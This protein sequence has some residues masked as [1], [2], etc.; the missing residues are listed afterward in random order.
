MT[1]LDRE[2]LNRIIELLENT[3]SKED[4]Y[5]A[6]HQYG[7]GTDESFA[8]ANKEGLELFAAQ[9]LKASLESENII[10]DEKKNIIPLD[11]D[12]E[13]IDG[14]IFIQYIE[15]TNKKGHEAKEGLYKETI[16]DKLI[17]IGC[18]GGL[19]VII[20]SAVVGIIS[21]FKWIF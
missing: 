19:V 10:N 16:F 9:L 4:A 8:K 12:E 13:W 15:P 17:P 2:E 11:Y 21:I 14:D 7:G 20:V 18:I 3:N 6:L 5:L 1:K